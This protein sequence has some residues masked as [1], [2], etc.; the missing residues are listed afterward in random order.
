MTQND[1]IVRLQRSFRAQVNDLEHDDYYDAIEDAEQDLGWT[2]PQTDGFKLKWLTKRSI[3]HLLF[4]LQTGSARK[5]RFE[6]AHLHHRFKH[7]STMIESMD[8]EYEKAVEENPHLFED[9]D[10]FRMFGYKA[11]A[12]FSSNELGEDTTYYDDNEII[13]EPNSNS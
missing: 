6:G 13:I 12:G 8:K 1:L 2:L 9:V 5:F 3:R 7:Y 10:A 11:D 4:L